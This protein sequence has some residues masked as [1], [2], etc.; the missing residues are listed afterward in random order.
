MYEN[1]SGKE[2]EIPVRHTANDIRHKKRGRIVKTA[3]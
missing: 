2:S 1:S 3:A